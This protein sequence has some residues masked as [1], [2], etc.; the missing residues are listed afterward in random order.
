MNA[1][2]TGITPVT[3]PL[4]SNYRHSWNYHPSWSPDG[5]KIAFATTRHGDGEI[6]LMNADGSD[7]LRLTNDI[8]YAGFPRLVAPMAVPSLSTPNATDTMIST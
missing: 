6:Y 7:P 1:D 8:G 2:G 3:D 5:T 4:S